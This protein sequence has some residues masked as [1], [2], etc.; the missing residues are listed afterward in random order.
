MSD[1]NSALARTAASTEFGLLTTQA[2]REIG[3]DSRGLRLRCEAGELH[4]VAHGVYMLDPPTWI[5]R[6][7][8]IARVRL[9]GKA[10]VSHRSAARLHGLWR[11]DEL[12]VT[13]RF[14]QRAVV[15]GASIHRSRDLVAGV[16]T[17]I[18]GLPVTTI[19]RTLC[20]L[21][22]VLPSWDVRHV[23]AHAL[24]T[25]NVTRSDVESVRWGV[26]EHGRNGVGAV[27]QALLEL[28][29]D[30][31]LTESG[32]EAVLLS[33]LE[34]IGPPQPI[35]QFSV[36][37]EEHRYRLDF[38]YPDEKVGIEYDGELFHSSSNQ[39][40]RDRIRQRRLERSG[41]LILRFDRHDLYSPAAGSILR[42]V[43]ESLRARSGC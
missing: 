30:A 41:W 23:V 10:V 21:G 8:A 40:A 36:R 32:P 11:G 22:L 16:I 31:S 12:D 19:A 25:G 3:L 33:L 5:D 28:S 42:R 38:A 20:D 1:L 39:R 9:A 17:S 35:P 2:L 4:R 29:A 27:D 26:S 6:V 34:A 13:I 7:R 18:G 14:P 15:P 37:I 43:R 24:A